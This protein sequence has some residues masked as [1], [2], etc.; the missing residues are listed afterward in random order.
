MTIYFGFHQEGTSDPSLTF[1]D[2]PFISISCA[3]DAEGVFLFSLSGIDD[4]SKVAL[5]VSPLEVENQSSGD[6]VIARVANQGN[7]KVLGRD[8]SGALSDFKMA[9]DVFIPMQLV[10]YP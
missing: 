8:S 7:L 6:Q 10:I 2:P 4:Y 3:R 9:E 1:V 5:F